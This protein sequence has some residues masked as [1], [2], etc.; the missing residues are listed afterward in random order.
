MKSNILILTKPLK[1]QKE[2]YIYVTFLSLSTRIFIIIQ[3]FKQN[4]F[5]TSHLSV[6]RTVFQK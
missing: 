4:V 6:Y 5:L 2:N 3:I 1:N